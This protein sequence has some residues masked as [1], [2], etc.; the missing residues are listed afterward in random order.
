[1]ERLAEI[2]AIFYERGKKMDVYDLKLIEIMRVKSCEIMN[3]TSRLLIEVPF[4]D[5]WKNNEGNFHGGAIATI[6]DL[7]TALS[8]SI[9]TNKYEVSV[10]LSVS[11]ISGLRD[12]ESI[13][14][15]AICYKAGKTISFTKA[16]MKA[17]SI[18]IAKANHILF[19][20]TT[21]IEKL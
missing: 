3:G 14:V 11:Y 18:L 13:Q 7:I 20:L 2:I 15:E 4:L 19:N 1:M 9:L 6:F 21:T 5:E 8:A 12:A 17:N 16:E 10:E